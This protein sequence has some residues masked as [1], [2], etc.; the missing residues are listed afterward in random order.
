MKTLA[1]I[2]V[3]LG[4]PLEVC[5]LEIPPLQRGQVLVEIAY[6]G[7]CHTQLLEARGQR[8]D[9]RYLPHCLGHEGSGIVREIGG[10][11]TKVKSGDHVILSWIKGSGADVASTHYSSGS[12]RINAGAITTFAHH[13]V[14]SENRLTPMP[15]RAPFRESA[16]LGCAIA[17]GAG[18]VL[19]VAQPRPGQ[20]LAVFGCGGIGLSAI[21]AAVISQCKPIFA[22]D[23]HPNR[24]ERAKLIGATDCLNAN[25][26]SLGDL[27][28]AIEA[29]GQPA[30]MTLALKSVRAR[31]GAAVIIGN[32]PHGAT[33][34]I[35]PHELNLGKRFLGTWGGDTQPDRD[36]PKYCDWLVHGNLTLAPLLSKPFR[37][38]Q[39]NEALAALESG[40]VARPLVAM[41]NVS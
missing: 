36:F 1:A 33:L 29:T 16:L 20:S 38:D 25:K 14:I 26:A 15:S 27:D 13:S 37:L 17:T 31:G 28:F 18:A 5:E 12:R 11:V 21:A 4:R 23:I 2:L 9:D 19:N 35:D 24:L 39:I 40:V 32:A 6:S 8:G 34:T 10:G 41:N 30:V 22:L 7:V 3:E